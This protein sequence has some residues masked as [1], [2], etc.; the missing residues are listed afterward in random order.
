M[1]KHRN[2]M[3]PITPQTTAIVVSSLPLPLL[4]LPDVVV[5]AVPPIVAVTGVVVVVCAA[6]VCALLDVV[7]AV[8]IVTSR[9]LPTATLSMA[10]SEVFIEVVK[11]LLV[12]EIKP[13]KTMVAAI[14]QSEVLLL[15]HLVVLVTDSAPI[16][17]TTRAPTTRSNA[18]ATLVMVSESHSVFV[19]FA[20]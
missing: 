20:T 8:P 13:E 3:P 5:D 19:T 6:S 2:T 16:P 7:T 18:S 12:V 11:V 4:E 15:P 9:I 1:R 10:A 14:V 17:S